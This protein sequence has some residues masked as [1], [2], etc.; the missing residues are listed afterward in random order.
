MAGGRHRAGPRLA[1]HAA[2]RHLVRALGRSDEDGGSNATISNSSRKLGS[3]TTKAADGAAFTITQV[4]ALRPTDS[5]S[6]KRRRF[7]PQDLLAPGA[8]RDL[9][10]PTVTDAE[11]LPLRSQRHMPNSIATLRIRLARTL[12]PLL[13]RC[14]CCGRTRQW[15]VE[16]IE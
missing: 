16:Q 2:S 9:A 1:L 4:S 6:P 11:A 10:F 13:P 3:A 5:W 12:V 14:P 7:P 8:A 15:S